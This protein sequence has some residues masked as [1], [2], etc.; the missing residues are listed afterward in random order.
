MFLL[1]NPSSWLSIRLQLTMTTSSPNSCLHCAQESYQRPFTRCWIRVDPTGADTW[2]LLVDW[3]KNT[4]GTPGT[5]E[6]CSYPPRGILTLHATPSKGRGKPLEGSSNLS[7]MCVKEVSFLGLLGEVS[8]FPHV[9]YL[10]WTFWILP[11]GH[12]NTLS[13]Q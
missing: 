13:T 10:Y 2:W 11:C 12:A 5:E 6:V 8:I 4:S 7:L 3:V 9:F 1:K